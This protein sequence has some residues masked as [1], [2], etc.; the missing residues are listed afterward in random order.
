MFS[1]TNNPYTFKY[2]ITGITG[3]GLTTVFLPEVPSE[4][5]ILFK[6]EKRFVKPVA[7]DYLKKA[8]KEMNFQRS[9]RN[10]KGEFIHPG[11]L[12]PKFQREIDEWEDREFKRASEGIWFYNGYDDLK[13]EPEIVYITGFHYWLLAAWNPYFGAPDFRDSDR[14]VCYFIK[15]C[16][17]DPNS[18]GVTF[19]TIRRWGKSTFMGAWIVYRATMNYT[20]NAGMQ[21]ETDE[22]IKKFYKKSVLKPFYKLP[23][24]FQPKYNT[25]T[26]QTNQIEFDIP[27]SRSSARNDV[28]E[29]ESLESMIDYRA[30]GE[31]E[32][33]GD[34]L[35]SYLMEEPG[36][37]KKV[38]IYNDEGEGRWDIVKPCFLQ[39]DEICGK[40]ILA[41]TVEN[42]SIA[43][44]GGKA[45]K[46]IV[47][48]SDFDQKQEDGRTISG[49]YFL[50]LPGDCALKGYYDTHGRPKRQEAKE[51]LMR[52]R[53]SYRNNSRKLAG[54]IRKY[55]L[56]IA[57]IF[58][59]SPDRCEFNAEILQERLRFI[60]SSPV[61]LISKY[62]LYWEN[63]VR[64][65]KVLWRH[66]PTGGW[67]EAT[68][69]PNR[70][71][72][73]NLFS[74]RNV[75]G[76]THYY[77]KDDGK[78]A[79][80]FDP[81]QHGS[82][83]NS[84]ESKPVLY[85]K[86]K[87]DSL[88]DGQ[89][90]LDDLINRAKPGKMINDQW[91]LDDSGSPYPYKTNQYI[92]RMAQRPSDP[93]VL[94]ERALMLCMW[95]GVSMHIEKQMGGACINYFHEWGCGDF[96]LGKYKPEFEKPEKTPT[97][98]TS[99][100]SGFI[101]EYT[102]LYAT[103]IEYF[104]HTMKFREQVEDAILFDASDPRV[105]DDTVAGG[106]A[107]VACKMK[108]KVTEKQVRNINDYFGRIN[109]D[110]YYEN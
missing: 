87:Y 88:I 108:P 2:L 21:G 5:Q 102:S 79:C 64:F 81:I 100:S 26:K 50:F 109:A 59:V 80:G 57:E 62:D 110:G 1:K 89:L 11:W 55:P 9:K 65:S 94:F 69:M 37:T 52:S 18:F 74:S 82:S 12:H 14:E 84:R 86:T 75:G 22:K 40:A 31:G 45:Y 49:L 25:D 54:W 27:P 44:K 8:M 91:I 85:I 47:Y 51:S 19:N 77:P 6:E 60:D 66:N 67:L 71:E 70:P 35:N 93:N 32:Y 104:G 17:E 3:P 38:S 33:D 106:L 61:P 4:D 98:G 105:H 30:S 58:Y 76:K 29:V 34:I 101:Q 15:Y 72:E 97:D 68:W 53:K 42:M 7:P 16:E 20:H 95:M 39:G 13:K 99:A 78:K 83:G 24:Y 107:E 73:Q 63:G 56:S 28:D 92:F 90:T 41:T 10:S 43:E 23:Y 48:D 46:K 96:I 36:K 103:Y